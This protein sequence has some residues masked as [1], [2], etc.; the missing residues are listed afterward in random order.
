MVST[1]CVRSLALVLGVLLPSRAAAQSP[2]DL[3]TVLASVERH[4]PLVAAAE[5]DRDIAAAELRA[6]EGSFDPQWRTR[7]A[8]TP[9]GYYNPLTLDTAIVQPTQIGRA[10]V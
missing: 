8:V 2:L 5:R 6:A 1:R 3:N 9:V 4:H 10:H 7:A